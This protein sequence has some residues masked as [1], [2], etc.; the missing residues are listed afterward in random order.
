MKRVPAIWMFVGGALLVGACTGEDATTTPSSPVPLREPRTETVRATVD[1]ETLTFPGHIWDPFMPPPSE[2]LPAT[3]AATLALPAADVQVPGVVITHGCGGSGGGAG[4][5]ARELVDFGYATLDIDSFR[6]RG[7]GEV[8]SGQERINIASVL[9]DVFRGL[10]LLAAHPGVD[11]SRIALLGLSFGGRTALWAN[12]TRFRDLY[13][14]EHEFAAHLSFYPASCYIRLADEDDIGDA[15]MRIFH[16]TADDWLPI[17]PC[18]EYVGRLQAA[19]RD[20]ALFEY[21]GALHAFDDLA[22][23]PFP[24]LL[25]SP[26]SPRNCSFFE[27][28]GR[29]ID[30]D[31]G[32]VAGVGSPCVES[33]VTSGYDPDAH[34]QAMV[35]VTTFLESV[36]TPS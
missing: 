23:G 9:N 24:A 17:E 20:V 3:I 21:E 19:G 12:Q 14:S 30:P 13:G 35:D 25:L 11:E 16:G 27:Q 34:A 31:T 36:L 22:P 4:M 1:I 32:E 10:D 15:P 6:G 8:C 5:W 2:A 7:I 18:R 33:G 28:D 29:I 26:L